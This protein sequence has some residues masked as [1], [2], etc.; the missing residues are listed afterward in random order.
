MS[1]TPWP[2]RSRS[3]CLS[4]ISTTYGVFAFICIASWARS[5]LG[6]TGTTPNGCQTPCPTTTSTKPRRRSIRRTCAPFP[7]S[8]ICGTVSRWGPRTASFGIGWECRTRKFAGCLDLGLRRAARLC[9]LPRLHGRRKERNHEPQWIVS[10]EPKNLDEQW[11]DALFGST[12]TTEGFCEGPGWCPR[13]FSES[14]TQ[15]I[16]WDRGGSCP[17]V[18]QP[19]EPFRLGASRF[20]LPRT[21]SRRYAS[22]DG[23]SLAPRLHP[24]RGSARW[25]GTNPWI[26]YAPV[27][28]NAFT[29]Q[30]FVVIAEMPLRRRPLRASKSRKHLWPLGPDSL[31]SMQRA[32]R[33]SY[34]TVVSG[35]RS[36]TSPVPFASTLRRPENGCPVQ[37]PSSARLCFAGFPWEPSR[38]RN[39]RKNSSPEPSMG[40]AGPG[41]GGTLCRCWTEGLGVGATN[42]LL[43]SNV[44]ASRVGT[45]DRGSGAP[46]GV[47][48][49]SVWVPAL[50]LSH[51]TWQRT[52]RPS[53][54]YWNRKYRNRPSR[55]PSRVCFFRA[56]RRSP[57]RAGCPS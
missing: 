33:F 41:A 51:H 19:C 24:T 56:P 8:W 38:P 45:N 16:R 35:S 48:L 3:S 15:Q 50:R 1:R 2:S 46:R 30:M 5:G 39:F 31:C 55:V 29:S 23:K 9:P 26:L 54:R 18:P 43:T 13:R 14:S 32:A 11:T 17:C 44:E 34:G 25:C 22:R 20:T 4:L 7:T 57:L 36:L 42:T 53:R 49:A 12:I 21:P 27:V 6:T 52:E 40:L 28:A 37:E 47:E 10:Q